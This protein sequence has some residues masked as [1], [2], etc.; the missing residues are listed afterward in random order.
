LKQA[1]IVGSAALICA[2]LGTFLQKG[3]QRHMDYATNVENVEGM[4]ELLKSDLDGDRTY[5][6]FLHL[7]PGF[8][9]RRSVEFNQ[10][11]DDYCMP[12]LIH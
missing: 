5:D 6:A 9:S 2:F 3:V 10:E 7:C 4:K 12:L 8:S 11:G 1:F